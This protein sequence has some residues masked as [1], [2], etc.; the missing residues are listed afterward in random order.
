MSDEREIMNFKLSKFVG[1]D[2]LPG[3]EVAFERINKLF[4]RYSGIVRYTVSRS[5]MSTGK[6]YGAIHKSSDAMTTL[7]GQVIDH[8][9]EVLD[10]SFKG[11]ATCQK[12]LKIQTLQ[13]S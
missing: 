5:V 13:Q 4:A 3:D 9:W 8:R 6:L 7:C 11:E 10:N 1:R 12:C 2:Q